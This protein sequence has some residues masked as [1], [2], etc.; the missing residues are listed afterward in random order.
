MLRLYYDSDITN[1]ET[2]YDL[3]KQMGKS[4]P[5]FKI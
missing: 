2:N 1:A 3:H 5:L 4:G